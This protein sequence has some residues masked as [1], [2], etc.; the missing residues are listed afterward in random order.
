MNLPGIGSSFCSVSSI[1]RNQEGEKQS[2][3]TNYSY[4]KGI[5]IGYHCFKQ[6]LGSDIRHTRKCEGV[7]GGSAGNMHFSC[8]A[9]VSVLCKNISRTD[10]SGW[11]RS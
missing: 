11:S 4:T 3:E 9:P 7:L 5:C 10:I 8:S 6:T 2:K 1:I